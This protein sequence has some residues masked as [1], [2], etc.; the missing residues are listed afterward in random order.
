MVTSRL[1]NILRAEFSY[2]LSLFGIVRVRH[3]P[4]FVSV[5]PANFCQLHCPEC[6]VG[7]NGS[8][9]K[10]TTLTMAQFE[11]ILENVRSSVHTIQF[12]FQGEPLLNQ[13]LPEMIKAASDAGIYT[14]V[15]TNAQALTPLLAERL[16]QSGLSRIIV[17]IDG[18]SEESYSAY[19]IGGNLHK[20]LDGLMYL[21]QA[22]DQNGSR[23]HIELQVLRLRSNEHEWKAMKRQYKVI[24]ADSITFKTAQLYNYE[25]GHPLMPTNERYSR[26]AKG[27]D[28]KYHLK[29]KPS[30][31]CK[32]LWTGCVIS[33][34]GEVLPCCYDKASQYSFG[35][36]FSSPLADIWHGEKANRFR[37]SV[38]KK[39]LEIPICRNCEP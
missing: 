1:I 30:R 32:R 14:I 36:I 19:R 15:S 21:R 27:T 8:K 25:N 35:N 7:K 23:T 22:K 6:P 13:Q 17:S 24:G 37:E 18:M 9:G 20:A 26:Y 11:R 29:R 4:T 28:G 33:V 31:S 5:E 34:T 3:L 12:F 10:G 38:L 39:R 16:V 2:A